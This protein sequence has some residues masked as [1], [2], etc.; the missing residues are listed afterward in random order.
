MRKAYTKPVIVFVDHHE[1]A[2]DDRAWI[3]LGAMGFDRRLV[4]PFRGEALG[5]PGPEV[6][7]TV[8]YGG[9]Q[10]VN[11]QDRFPFLGDE[12]R[13][14]ERCLDR[15]LPVLGLCLG[16]QL[17]A[18]VLG[19]QVGSRASG[20]CEFG[21][22]PLTPT[23]A[24]RGWLPDGMH[25]TQAHYEEFDIPAGAVHLASGERFAHQAFRYGENAFGLQFHPE[26]SRHIFRRW[27]A[28]EWAMFGVPGAQEKHEQDR[29]ME[30]HDDAQGRWFHGLLESLFPITAA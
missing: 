29:L 2:M 23:A 6:A 19:A 25:V 21:Y 4:C 30:Q 20:E 16:G 17:L 5:D 26:I 8:I 3:C 1:N 22:Y 7:G 10:S 18:R 13:W 11:E 15:G 14:I 9:A 12:I 24:G 27:Q 28:A